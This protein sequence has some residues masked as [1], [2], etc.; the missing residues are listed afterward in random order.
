LLAIIEVY[1]GIRRSTPETNT[2]TQSNSTPTVQTEP[3]CE[4]HVTDVPQNVISAERRRY[5]Q[6][7]GTFDAQDGNRYDA[8]ERIIRGS[9]INPYGF[10]SIAPFF[11]LIHDLL[12]I[13][14]REEGIYTT[15]QDDL[16]TEATIRREMYDLEIRARPGEQCI[17][18]F[19]RQYFSDMPGYRAIAEM[20]RQVTQNSLVCS[21]DNGRVLIRPTTALEILLRAGEIYNVCNRP[22]DEE[23]L[24]I[25]R[26]GIFIDTSN[27]FGTVQQSEEQTHMQNDQNLMQP[28]LASRYTLL[29]S[30]GYS[31]GDQGNGV[32][33]DFG[34]TF[35][36]ANRLQ[37]GYVAHFSALFQ[38]TY[39]SLVGTPA[40]EDPDQLWSTVIQD[41]T[42]T[43]YI[44]H[45][46]PAIRLD[47][48]GSALQLNCGVGID[49]QRT[50]QTVTVRLQNWDDNVFTKTDSSTRVSVGVGGG[51]EIALRH[52]G[53]GLYGRL[54][55][56]P[57]QDGLPAV[58]NGNVSVLISYDG[59]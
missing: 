38:N 50:E 48:G 39:E 54:N 44:A 43:N 23:G 41:T 27:L 51:F 16:R 18:T 53:L 2:T 40:L 33:V 32:G 10:R 42:D 31:G 20:A 8:L 13:E 6:I 29:F 34:T 1:A 30:L 35:R 17:D 5:Q 3:N 12:N 19:T 59:N 47:L 7:Y 11:Q 25:N 57:E 21:T 9:N 55:I 22:L 28:N 37:L 4:V 56:V 15:P 58:F 52:I 45:I 36:I 24:D 26:V 46:G 14:D 49:Y